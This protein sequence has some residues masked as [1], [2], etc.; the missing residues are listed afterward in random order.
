MGRRLAGPGMALREASPRAESANSLRRQRDFAADASH[1]LRTPLAII[2]ARPS[3]TLRRP[4]G[5]AHGP[6][7]T[8][9]RST[10]FAEET[11]HLSGLVE[12]PLGPH[13]GGPRGGIEIERTAVDLAAIAVSAVANLESLARDRNIELGLTAEPAP[14]DGDART[15][16]PACH[17]PR[18][19][20]H[21]TFTEWRLVQREHFT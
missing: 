18:R 20:C 10:T 16:P 8:L 6:R 13:P 14:L 3:M 11:D 9:Q 2:T 7:R 15:T 12:R 19:Q 5:R 1:E 4:S 21:P 17:H